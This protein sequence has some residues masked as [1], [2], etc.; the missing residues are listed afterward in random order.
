V[1]EVVGQG[2]RE[3]DADQWRK[4]LRLKKEPRT[5]RQKSDIEL[6]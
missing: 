4:E 5:I 1:N 6:R 2:K 3:D